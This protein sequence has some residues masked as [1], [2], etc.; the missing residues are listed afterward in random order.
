MAVSPS[1][2]APLGRAVGVVLRLFAEP[3]D[4]QAGVDD[5][6][7]D[8]RGVATAGGDG[9][10]RPTRRSVDL[11]RRLHAARGPA[12]AGAQR[13]DVV[14][15]R[16]RQRGLVPRLAAAGGSAAASSVG[17]RRIGGGQRGETRRRPP[18]LGVA[19]D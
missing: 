7:V 19:A 17:R 5:R 11:R 14:S 13:R 8:D 3:V 12:T 4:A 2:D 15:V 9:A 6:G 16:H 18:H 1:A 10:A